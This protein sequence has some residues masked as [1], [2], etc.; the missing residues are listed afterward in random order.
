MNST[1]PVKELQWFIYELQNAEFNGEKVHILGHIPPGHPDCLK[2]WSRNYYAIISRYESTITAQFF[3]HT[4]FD[5]FE[6]FYDTQDLGRPVS[7]AYIGPSVTPYYDLNPGYRIYYVDGDREHS[8]RAVLDHETWVMNL[9][10]ANLY[11]YPIW[12]KLYSTQAAYNLPSL[13]PEDWDV[14]VNNLAEDQTSF[15]LYYKHY[16]K[17]S[18]TRPVC[19]A[20]CKKRMICDLRSGRSH[21]RK[22]LCQEI[23][24]RIDAGARISWSAWLYNGFTASM[25]VIMSIPHYT[26]Q[27]PKYLLGYA[28]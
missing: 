11:D 13:R 12:E 8:T 23:E 2:V 21:D 19:D 4:H 28:R 27:I 20:E 24:S 5:E 14:F 7:I 1:D 22:I 25:S 16:W 6:L 3:G 17:N 26:Y 9:K 18:P 10:E 15:D